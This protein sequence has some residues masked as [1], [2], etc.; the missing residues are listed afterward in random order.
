MLG[1]AHISSSIGFCLTPTR[2]DHSAGTVK[3]PDNSPTIR[4]TAIHDASPTSAYVIVT[5]T[6]VHYIRHCTFYKYVHS[7]LI[8][9]KPNIHKA[10]QDLQQSSKH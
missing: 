5:T 9:D 6:L 10:I 3:F 1:T 7:D 8:S 2:G 4:R